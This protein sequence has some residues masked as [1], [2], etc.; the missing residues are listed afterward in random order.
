M[1]PQLIIEEGN[2]IVH[3]WETRGRAIVEL[4]VD[5]REARCM[6]TRNRSAIHA[7]LAQTV[8][9]SE[10]TAT[11]ATNLGVAIPQPDLCRR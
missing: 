1:S 3:L 7:E 8:G 2:V 4:K 11:W 9:T 6:G 10:D 5:V